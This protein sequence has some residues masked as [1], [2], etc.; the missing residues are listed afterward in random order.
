MKLPMIRTMIRGQ[1]EWGSGAFG[2]PRDGGSRK[3]NGID[4]VALPG[5]E[6]CTLTESRV[7]RIGYPYD[8][9]PSSELDI[10]TDAARKK[11]DLKAQMRLIVLE[12]PWG[13][14][15]KLMYVLPFDHVKPGRKLPQYA[16]IGT[17]Q[18]LDP[19]YPGITP[20][21]HFEV[22]DDQGRI[23]NPTDYLEYRL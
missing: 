2:A 19:I 9:R 15:I 18:D 4:I 3:H 7:I 8:P 1:D 10:R 16:S 23:I 13:N 21:F 20:H 12:D 5:S 14:Q 22:S 11:H 17:T 6:P